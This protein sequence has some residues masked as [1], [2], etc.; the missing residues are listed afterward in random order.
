M[1][2]E[3]RAR[4]GTISE[5]QQ[6]KHAL[7]ELDSHPKREKKEKKLKSRE[8]W[9]QIK[10]TFNIFQIYS[11]RREYIDANF[12]LLGVKDETLNIG[13]LDLN[14]NILKL[15]PNRNLFSGV[16]YR[17]EMV[18]IGI[19]FFQQIIHIVVFLLKVLKIY[20]TIYQKF[21]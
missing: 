1:S 4:H 5:L 3:R 11:S 6:C 12:V 17:P 19:T 2:T 15:G 18:S 8:L 9:D 13:I 20:N 10:L 7:I 16:F 21:K 14:R